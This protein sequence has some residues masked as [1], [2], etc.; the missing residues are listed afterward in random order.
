MAEDFGLVQFGDEPYAREA[1]GSQVGGE[2]DRPLGDTRLVRRV[3]GVD[4]TVL[5]RRVADVDP[6][7]LVFRRIERGSVDFFKIVQ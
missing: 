6:F 4:Q 7:V 2:A 3:A 1:K 5:K